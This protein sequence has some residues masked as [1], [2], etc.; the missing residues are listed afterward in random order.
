MSMLANIITGFRVLCS[1]LLM[2]VPTF[3]VRFYI[4]YFLCGISDMIDGTVA[5]KTNSDSEFGAKF[6]KMLAKHGY[7]KMVVDMA[8]CYCKH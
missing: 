2:F 3:S 1:V 6:D 4:A 8:G 7:F 5:R